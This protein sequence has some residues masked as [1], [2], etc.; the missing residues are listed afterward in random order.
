[1]LFI[2]LSSILFVGYFVTALI[3]TYIFSYSSILSLLSKRYNFFIH[4]LTYRAIG[5][6][7]ST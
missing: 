1:M 4:T 5:K 2:Q 3:Y 7:Y 6:I